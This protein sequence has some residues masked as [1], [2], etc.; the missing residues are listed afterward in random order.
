VLASFDP[1]P[2]MREP[3][4]F[5]SAPPT[6]EGRASLVAVD[7][8]H[9]LRQD[10]ESFIQAVY[11]ARYGARL[12]VFMPTLVALRDAQGDL[13]AA[14]GYR[15]AGAHALFLE[16]YL[17]RP[18]EQLLAT[19]AR[20]PPPRRRIVEVGHLAAA[21]AG[22]G[23]RLILQL[24]PQLASQGFEWVV[25]TLTEELRHLFKRLGLVPVALGMADPALL[26]AEAADW[27]SYYE[28]HP[29]VLAGQIGPALQ[30]LARQRGAA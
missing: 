19:G 28:H 14:A 22:Q 18:V 21:Q 7:Q 5:P 9:P 8:R 3:K 11:R 30:A 13:L 24:G 17:D 26:G 1:R 27:G 15:D 2:P 29:L 10:T 25:S 16:R 12:R 6:A 4:P 23:R 20:M